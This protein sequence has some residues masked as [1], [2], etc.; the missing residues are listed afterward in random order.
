MLCDSR[1]GI[2]FAQVLV[3]AL[4][5]SGYTIFSASAFQALVST[6]GAGGIL[7]YSYQLHCLLQGLFWCSAIFLRI[8]QS[9]GVLAP[10]GCNLAPLLCVGAFHLL[11]GSE[12]LVHCT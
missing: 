1:Y 9:G 5:L 12:F 8:I 4:F 6:S 3:H 7:V 2:L 11:F 10:S